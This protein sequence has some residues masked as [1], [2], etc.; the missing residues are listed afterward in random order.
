MDPQEKTFEQA[1]ES[2]I[3]GKSKEEKEKD[4]L[5]AMKSWYKDVVDIFGDAGALGLSAW[6]NDKEKIGLSF[7][8]EGDTP[9]TEFTKSG[10]LDMLGKTIDNPN[11]LKHLKSYILSLD[12]KK[13]KEGS[14][15]T[16]PLKLPATKSISN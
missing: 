6:A 4:A 14:P 11:S 3:T 9:L 13:L 15:A 16:E 8:M 10:K 12:A 7:K 1:V 2:S 5:E